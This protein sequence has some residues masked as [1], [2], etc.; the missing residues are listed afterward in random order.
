MAYGMLMAENGYPWYVA[1]LASVIVYTGAFQFVLVS[2]L[3][4]GASLGLVAVT[5]LLMNSRQTFYSLSFVSDFRAM[6][7]RM[8]YMVYTMTDES[9]AVNCSLECDD[10]DRQDVMFYV[11]ILCRIYWLLGTVLG[12]GVGQSLPF[13]LTGIDF[14]H[15]GAVYAVLLMDRVGRVRRAAEACAGGRG[16]CYDLPADFQAA[17]S[18]MLPALLITSRQCSGVSLTAGR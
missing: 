2:L 14:C 18:F 9:Y 15:D 1:L 12:A 16:H 6:G 11:A 13:D 8:P 17:G 5:A 3:A 10:P 7:R 4:G